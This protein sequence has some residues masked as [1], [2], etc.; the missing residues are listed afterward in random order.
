MMSMNHVLTQLTHDLDT[1]PDCVE[2]TSHIGMA[3]GGGKLYLEDI[4]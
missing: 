4:F 2:S 1:S 3:L